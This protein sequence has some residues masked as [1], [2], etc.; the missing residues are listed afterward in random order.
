MNGQDFDRARAR[1]QQLAGEA[2]RLEQSLKY[3]EALDRYRA[4]QDAWT[5]LLN[6]FSPFMNYR[7]KAKDALAALDTTIA[8]VAQAEETLQKEGARRSGDGS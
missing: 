5:P 4:A 3:D 8:R 1:R 2:A 6:R 7:D